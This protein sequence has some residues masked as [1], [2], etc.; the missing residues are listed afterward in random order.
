MKKLYSCLFV[1]LCLFAF[2]GQVSA[3]ADN[4]L[5]QNN[6]VIASNLLGSI[7]GDITLNA[8]TLK[9]ALSRWNLSNLLGGLSTTE[10]RTLIY[11]E[12]GVKL[13]LAGA[14]EK[15]GWIYKPVVSLI[16]VMNNKTL[17]EGEPETISGILS[18]KLGYRWDG[19]ITLGIDSEGQSLVINSPD[20]VGKDAVLEDV[21]IAIGVLPHNEGQVKVDG[22]IYIDGF[23]VDIGVLS[24]IIDIIS[25][26]I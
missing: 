10:K 8:D 13:Y 2:A 23:P 6:E 19:Y 24:D 18:F 16:V 26:Q 17:V 1:I 25:K 14:L 3:E 11:E 7:A 9:K 20:T 21:T 15:D 4:L 5:S 12:D 22:K